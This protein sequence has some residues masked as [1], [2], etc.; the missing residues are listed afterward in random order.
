VLKFVNLRF[1][2]FTSPLGNFHSYSPSSPSISLALL[3]LE[4]TP[5]RSPYA[6]PPSRPAPCPQS[7][8]TLVVEPPCSQRALSATRGTLP[9]LR[10][11]LRAVRRSRRPDPVQPCRTVHAP[12]SE[13]FAGIRAPTS[14][15]LAGVTLSAIAP[16]PATPP[17]HRPTPRL[18][19]P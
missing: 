6:R 11:C 10:Q 13:R 19:R 12:P 4:F 1:A 7:R 8:H 15:R 14:E 17:E 18:L 9:K 5:R 16:C 3:N 2:L